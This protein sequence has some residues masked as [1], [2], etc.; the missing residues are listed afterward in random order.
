MNGFEDGGCLP[1][2]RDQQRDVLQMEGQVWWPGRIRSSTPQV[3]AD[4]NA[5]LKKLLA[6]AML[7]NAMLKDLNSKKW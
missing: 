2:A 6:E 3:L 1:Q 7:D 4:E 5:K